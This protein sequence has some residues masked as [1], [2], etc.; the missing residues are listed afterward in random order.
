[1]RLVGYLK[2]NLEHTSEAFALLQLTVG[3]NLEV[4]QMKRGNEQS[5]PPY[6]AR[7]LSSSLQTTLECDGSITRLQ[8]EP[9]ACYSCRFCR[10]CVI[11]QL[12]TTDRT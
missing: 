6:Y 11:A 10:R 5:T 8:C 3:S 12:Q 2:I 9:G 1:V 4:S 7:S